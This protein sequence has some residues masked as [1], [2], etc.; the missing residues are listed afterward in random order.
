MFSNR[1][2]FTYATVMIIIVATILATASS[3]LKPYQQKNIELEKIKNILITAGAIDETQKYSSDELYDRFNKIITRQVVVNAKGE[4]LEGYKAFDIDVA[5]EYKKPNP[6]DRLLPVFIATLDNGETCYIVPLR[7][8]GL[9]GPIWGY[10][11]LKDDLN[12][13]IGAVF[14]H[15]G[16]TPGLGAEI[17]TPKFRQQ[18]VGEKIYDENGQFVSIKV[19]KGGAKPD[20]IHGVDAISG[21]TITSRGVSKML[22]DNL[23]LYDNYFKTLIKN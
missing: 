17:V 20:D 15:K 7:G 18:F 23:K 14:D 4:V 12:T 21:G 5:A 19:V 6:E 2:I 8:K 1:Y 11:A 13:V 16:E 3:L 22:Y 9:W 10:I